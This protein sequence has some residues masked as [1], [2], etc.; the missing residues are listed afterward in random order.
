MDRQSF[1]QKLD[2]CVWVE[3]RL[4]PARLL[5]LKKKIKKKSNKNSKESKKSQAGSLL[6]NLEYE[7]TED[8]EIRLLKIYEFLLKN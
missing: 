5:I 4:F 2:T 3:K 6:V 7:P 1:L 8:A